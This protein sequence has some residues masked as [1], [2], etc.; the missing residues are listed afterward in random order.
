MKL[1]IFYIKSSCDNLTHCDVD[2]LLMS[3]FGMLDGKSDV[4]LSSLHFGG[5][6]GSGSGTVTSSPMPLCETFVSDSLFFV[7]LSSLLI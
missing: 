3:L 2:N 4:T 7:A 6:L 5:D 1:A